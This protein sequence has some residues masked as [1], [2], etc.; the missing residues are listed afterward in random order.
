MALEAIRHRYA[1]K[2]SQP[3]PDPFL[4]Q[5][6]PRA[7]APLFIEHESL[8]AEKPSSVPADPV[9]EA[10]EIELEDSDDESLEYVDE[11]QPAPRSPSLPPAPE[12]AQDT[13]FIVKDTTSLGDVTPAT[14]N[15]ISG[16][17]SRFTPVSD[18]T[19]KH[20]SFV[21]SAHVRPST[22]LANTP[23]PAR[24][25]SLDVSPR[26]ASSTEGN[27][28]HSTGSMQLAARFSRHDTR[29][30]PVASTSR[31]EAHD[32][33]A[34]PSTAFPVSVPVGEEESSHRDDDELVVIEEASA[35]RSET[36]DKRPTAVSEGELVPSPDVVPSVGVVPDINNAEAEI[37][38]SP[39]PPPQ[40][41]ALDTTVPED[42]PLLEP[43]HELDEEEEAYGDE[44]EEEAA[45]NMQQE[46]GQFAAF[47]SQL[48]NRNLDDM[49]HEIQNEIHGLQKQQVKDRRNADDVTL[50]MSKEIRVRA[51]EPF[52][53]GTVLLTWAFSICSD[54]LVSPTWTLPWKLR[55]NALSFSH[56]VWLTV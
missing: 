25:N 36:P 28:L 50:Q 29:P 35:A 2:A 52:Y 44:D 55:R 15:T 48:Q 38:W 26:V 53:R 32:I 10:Q 45:A 20:E 12:T 16:D 42:F 18:S 11:L 49:Q 41:K 1:P 21:S 43:G 31:L 24:T 9:R 56:A 51:N 46:Q 7:G 5:P 6:K 3:A 23:S 8:P 33:R 54:F 27:L 39:S 13:A 34:G 30:A 37:E 19:S 47:F 40:P 4:Q 22:P 17:S 14:S